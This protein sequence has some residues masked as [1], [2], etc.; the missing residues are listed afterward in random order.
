MREF[1]MRRLSVFWRTFLLMLGLTILMFVALDCSSH[2]AE[3]TL[4]KN[5]LR[6]AQTALERN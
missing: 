5:Y 4:L 2:T 1:F 6:Q 3:Q